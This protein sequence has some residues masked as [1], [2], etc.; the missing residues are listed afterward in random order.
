ME[1]LVDN[2]SAGEKEI[3]ANMQGTKNDVYY[4]PADRAFAAAIEASLA[5]LV[6]N[7]V[8]LP[9]TLLSFIN[10]FKQAQMSVARQP[11]EIPFLNITYRE[12]NRRT[13]VDINEEEPI[14][15]AESASGIQSVVPM[16]LVIAQSPGQWIEEFESKKLHY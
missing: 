10:E 16:L 15:L 6:L 7:N 12:I 5:G 14:E 13:V 9:A 8:A 2:A 4:I 1:E 3:I 11:L